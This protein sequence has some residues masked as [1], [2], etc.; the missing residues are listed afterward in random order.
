MSG[1]PLPEVVRSLFEAAPG[2]GRPE[3]PGWASGEAREALSATHVRIHLEVGD[4]RIRGFR[5]EA[6]GCPYTLAL[7]GRLADRLAGAP[8]R[9]AEALAL[10]DLAAELGAP[11]GKLGR[12]LVVQDAM[13]AALLQTRARPA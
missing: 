12:F 1:P 5:W 7:L 10:R 11:P 9:E 13:T 8:V 6:R 4:G 2:A 3:G